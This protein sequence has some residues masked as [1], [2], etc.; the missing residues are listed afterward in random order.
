MI[1]CDLGQAVQFNATA[2]AKDTRDVAGQIFTYCPSLL[3]NTG[4]NESNFAV[5]V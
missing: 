2:L 1:D 4:R 3:E 5:R